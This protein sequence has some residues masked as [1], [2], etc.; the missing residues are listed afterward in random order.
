MD[1]SATST[2]ITELLVASLAVIAVVLLL[3]KRYDSNIPLLFYFFLIL[4]TNLSDRGLH[5]VLLYAGLIVALLLRFEFMGKGVVRFVA[6][7]TN[8]TLCIIVYSMVMDVLS[9]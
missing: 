9:V 1:F 3:R 6:F 7:L 8:L 2:N 5:P 4:F